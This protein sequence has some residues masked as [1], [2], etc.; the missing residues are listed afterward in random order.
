M[1]I[2][3]LFQNKKYFSFESEKPSYS[4][5]LSRINGALLYL[6]YVTR[7]CECVKEFILF[8]NCLA[9][10]TNRKNKL[11]QKLTNNNFNKML[12]YDVCY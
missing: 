12:R 11:M 5:F 10:Y 4:R 3:F 2:L 1:S 8:S 9:Q 7:G 6:S